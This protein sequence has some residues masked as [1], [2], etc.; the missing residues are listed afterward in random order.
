MRNLR[1]LDTQFWNVAVVI[2]NNKELGKFIWNYFKISK[3]AENAFSI[4]LSIQ[5]WRSSSKYRKT[6]DDE[7]QKL[8]WAEIQ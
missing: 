7:S 2:K 1:R 4:S 5:L 8:T 3:T 6:E